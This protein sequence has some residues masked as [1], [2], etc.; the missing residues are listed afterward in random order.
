[1]R[2]GHDPAIVYDPSSSSFN[3]LNGRGS[4]LG[5]NA[6][7]KFEEYKYS[8]WPKGQIIVIGTDGIWETEN[9]GAEKF[10]KRRLREIIR[11]NSH[12]PAEEILHAIT[13][14]LAAFRQTAPQLDD[15]TLVVVKAK[16]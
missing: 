11:Q 13:D 15:V 16:T 9:T 14:K 12:G 2:A 3:E 7:W 8:G 4:V 5:I 10:G 6:D 1:V